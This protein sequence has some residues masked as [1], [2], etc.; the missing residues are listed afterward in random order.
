M[1]NQGTK[2]LICNHLQKSVSNLLAIYAF[3]SRIQGT[4]NK[5]SDLDLAIMVTGYAEPLQLWDLS[6]ELANQLHYE[7][8]LLDLRAVST[9]MQYQVITTGRR[10]WAKDNQA[11]CFDAFVL[12]E[13]LSL[14]EA[15]KK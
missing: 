1:L 15:R 2:I 12:N 5:D 3:G 10:L 9:V 6:N 11:D 14:D 13:K 4:A 7:V 8:D